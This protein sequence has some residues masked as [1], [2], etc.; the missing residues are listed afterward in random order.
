MPGSGPL[1]RVSALFGLAQQRLRALSATT[2]TVLG[3]CPVLT[4]RTS[5]A[6][7]ARRVP[8]RRPSLDLAGV[9]MRRAQT[10]L[11]P[12]ATTALLPTI[13][14]ASTRQRTSWRWTHSATVP[15]ARV[16]CQ[17]RSV[18]RAR[19]PRATAGLGV[20][21]CEPLRLRCGRSGPC[22][23][24]VVLRTWLTGSGRCGA[25]RAGSR[26]EGSKSDKRPDWAN[27]QEKPSVHPV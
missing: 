23:R 27:F 1:S 9:A 7:L 8:L 4:A 6:R 26:G 17:P 25:W 19:V 11:V 5:L 20:P 16:R 10:A 3:L 13:A 18:A 12:K 22:G 15:T 14:A 2:A 24:C 21:W